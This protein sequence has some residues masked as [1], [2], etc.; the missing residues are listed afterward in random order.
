MLR[1]KG[2]AKGCVN[3]IP[4]M[5]IGKVPKFLV[6]YSNSPGKTFKGAAGL[7]V[8]QNSGE[9]TRLG[10]KKC[11]RAAKTVVGKTI[12]CS[13]DGACAQKVLRKDNRVKVSVAMPVQWAVRNDYNGA[14]VAM[15]EEKG[16]GALRKNGADT[17]RCE[18]RD[19]SAERQKIGYCVKE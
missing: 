2:A 14:S 1:K 8:V 15:I 9:A 3:K 13:R 18:P 19:V 6:G 12:Q 16:S 5:L 4:T 17:R 7:R 11:K 10:F